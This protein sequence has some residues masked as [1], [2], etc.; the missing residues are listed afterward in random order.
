[1]KKL[2]TLEN[3]MWMVSNTEIVYVIPTE[4]KPTKIWSIPHRTASACLF[5]FKCAKIR[6]NIIGWSP[7]EAL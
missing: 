1:M 3:T 6:C 7:K 4:L 5:V 2:I